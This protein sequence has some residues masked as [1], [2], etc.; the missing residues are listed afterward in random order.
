M[1]ERITIEITDRSM[2]AAC[3]ALSRWHFHESDVITEEAAIRAILDALSQPTAS[4]AGVPTPLY[5]KSTAR[6]SC[7]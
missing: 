3:K 5:R 4:P 1:S 2:T 6:N 7:R